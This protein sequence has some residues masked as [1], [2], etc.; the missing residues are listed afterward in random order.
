[1]CGRA[2]LPTDYSEIKIKLRFDDRWPAPNLKQSWNIAPT[3]PML[4]ARAGQ[5]ERHA[6]PVS[7]TRVSAAG[8]PHSAIAAGCF[9]T[10]G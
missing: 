7:S 9:R 2:K 1:M 3:D 10:S 4:T 8:M 6:A 5:G